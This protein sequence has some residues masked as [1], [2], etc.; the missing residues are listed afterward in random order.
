MANKKSDTPLA[1]AVVDLFKGAEAEK[2]RKGVMA[3]YVN[4]A[5]IAR[6]PKVADEYAKLPSNVRAA[7]ARVAGV[8]DARLDAISHKGRVKMLEEVER[9]IR[10]LEKARE[11]LK[12]V[13]VVE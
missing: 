8:E 11:L 4:P 12:M 2:N 7:I 6:L 10:N 13:R 1:D 9:L 3:K 5:R